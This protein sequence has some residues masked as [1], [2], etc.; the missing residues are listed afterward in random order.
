MHDEEI[1]ED[2]LEDE[3][4]AEPEV[5][6]EEALAALPP[7]EQVAKLRDKLKEQKARD[8]ARDAKVEGLEALIA[9]IRNR[10]APTN[11][12]PAPREREISPEEKERLAA[13]ALLELNTDPDAFFAKRDRRIAEQVLRSVQEANLPGDVSAFDEMVDRYVDRWK[14]DNPTVGDKAEKIF[15]DQMEAVP[16]EQRAKFVR[17]NPKARKEILDK[18]MDAA[19]YRFLKPRLKPKTSRSPSTPS[20]NRSMTENRPNRSAKAGLTDSQ[21]AEMK[22]RGV[23]D[24]RIK[25]INDQIAAA[26]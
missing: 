19:A 4:E 22:R 3:P 8:A 9:E 12:Q 11:G 2:E 20:G 6:E 26:V 25:A 14:R 7:E 23:S 17:A 13:E 15:R 21:K 16:P 1:D 18:E 10:P 5:D 24:E